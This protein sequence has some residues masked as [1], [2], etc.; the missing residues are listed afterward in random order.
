MSN[1]YFEYVD[2]CLSLSLDPIQEKEYKHINNQ[3]RYNSNGSQKIL[4]AN[5]TI[6]LYHSSNEE[7]LQTF[8]SFPDSVKSP[9]IK[10]SEEKINLI[11]LIYKDVS[12]GKIVDFDKYAT[13]VSVFSIVHRIPFSY[14]ENFLDQPWSV[15]FYLP[16][17][18]ECTDNIKFTWNDALRKSIDTDKD[19][20]EKNSDNTSG[21]R[22]LSPIKF[23]ENNRYAI[24]YNAILA[25]PGQQNL[26]G[27]F[28]TNSFIFTGKKLSELETAGGKGYTSEQSLASWL[29]EGLE[30][31]YLNIQSLHGDKYLS[32]NMEDKEKVI[33]EFR[34][35]AILPGSLKEINP[36]TNKWAYTEVKEILTEKITLAPRSLVFCPDFGSSEFIAA[37]TSSTNGAASGSNT[38]EATIQGIL[39]LVERDA[40]W[41]YCRT[42]AEPFAIP[43]E[44]I[45]ETIKE[46]I[47]SQTNGVFYFQLLKSPFDIHV[48]QSTYLRKVPDIGKSITARGTGASHILEKAIFRSFAECVQLLDSLDTGEEIQKND[49]DMRN[50]WYSG[51][52]V[53]VF[54]RFFKHSLPKLVLDCYKD[55]PEPSIASLLTQ[56]NAQGMNFY[57]YP[58]YVSN[59]VSVVKSLSNEIN[60]LD[61]E[62]YKQSDRIS[63]FSE[64]TGVPFKEIKYHESTFM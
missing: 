22:S 61:S 53:K 35:P 33:E 8:T 11:N 50:I 54:E 21:V 12:K 49:F 19:K 42:D 64:Q 1:T 4:A 60:S 56:A 40:F 13:L 20:N 15:V 51:E 57:Y 18:H 46:T 43:Y 30:R 23:I 62:F 3:I 16:G 55:F 9:C 25:N 34:L 2:I 63:R 41:F 31:Y 39:E 48:V 10:C 44:F 52:S 58:L 45:P 17:C 27:V 14:T 6:T 38:E 7:G 29:G 28:L 26:M 32:I 37:T 36:Y 59:N 24:G 47:S 5:S